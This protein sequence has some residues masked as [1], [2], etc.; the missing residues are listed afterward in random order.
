MTWGLQLSLG[1]FLAK[2]INH[3]KE[4]HFSSAVILKITCTPPEL[5]LKKCVLQEFS[6][7]GLDFEC[8]SKI[9]G[10]ACLPPG[11]LAWPGLLGPGPNWVGKDTNTS[12]DTA[13]G[14]EV[15]PLGPVP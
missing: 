10:K 4:I 5:S 6:R 13:L 7:T 3:R 9:E 1:N 15:Q 8:H 2:L 11:C 14:P 12:G